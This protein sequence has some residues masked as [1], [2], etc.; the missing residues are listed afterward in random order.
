MRGTEIKGL[1]VV[2]IADG[3]R[4]GRIDRL[5]ID[6]HQRVIAGFDVTAPGGLLSPGPTT[7]IRTGEIHALGRDALTINR[8]DILHIAGPTLDHSDLFELDDLRKDKVGTE[9]GEVVGTVVDFEFDPKTFALTEMEVSPG[10]F[11]PNLTV[12]ATLIVSMGKDLVIV[13]DEVLDALQTPQEH[14][15]LLDTEPGTGS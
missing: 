12:P 3:E 13:R 4:V 11:K 1:S 15:D 10:L 7:F 9:S 8:S 6:P 2:S 14:S 5:F